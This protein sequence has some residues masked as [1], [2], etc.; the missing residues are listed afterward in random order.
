MNIMGVDFSG[1]RSDQNTWLAQGWLDDQGLLLQECLPVTRAQLTQLLADAPAPTIAALDFPFSVPQ[2]FARFWQ[3]DAT[4][5]SDLWATASQM[6]FGQFLD[7]RHQFVAQHGEPKRRADT[8]FP[9]CYSC[10]HLANPNMVPMTF[11]G[12]QMLHRLRQVGCAMPPLAA[13]VG[14]SPVLLEAMPGAALKAFGLP[15]KGYKKGTRSLELRQTILDRLAESSS[16]EVHVLS[17]YQELCLSN[18]DCLDS[19]VAA[20]VAALWARDPDLFWRPPEEGSP[21]FDP[22]VLLEGWLYAPVYVKQ[23]LAQ[24]NR[25]V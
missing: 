3:P 22:V 12:M 8:H 11:R 6:D 21:D 17:Q 19:V 25:A 5:M 4:T 1:A 18:H 10:L 2:E 13:P 16:I 23:Q 9:E 20:V 14:T 7:L 15:Y 24:T